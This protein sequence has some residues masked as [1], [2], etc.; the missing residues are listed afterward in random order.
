MLF[1]DLTATSIDPI[2]LRYSDQLC[3]DKKFWINKKNSNYAT[4]IAI[5]KLFK[6][7]PFHINKK[8]MPTWAVLG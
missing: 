1:F 3:V 7:K 4:L 8:G 5:D 2:K 6:L